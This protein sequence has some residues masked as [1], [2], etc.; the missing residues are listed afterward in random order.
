LV[1]FI[2]TII[3]FFGWQVRY[4]DI[5]SGQVIINANQAPLKPGAMGSGKLQLKNIKSQ[6]HFKENQVIA[7][8]ENSAYVRM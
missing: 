7:Y 1:V 3:L 4:P 6:D 2:I 8:Q 5:V